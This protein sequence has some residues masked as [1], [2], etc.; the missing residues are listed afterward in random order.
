MYWNLHEEVLKLIEQ[1]PE[2]VINKQREEIN[3]LK[4]EI[5]SQKEQTIEVQT[6]QTNQLTKDIKEIKELIQEKNGKEFQCSLC[7]FTS[8][9]KETVARH[10]NKKI[11][12]GEGE[13]VILEIDVDIICE[14]CKKEFATQPSLK[15]HQKTCKVKK[16][17]TKTE[18]QEVKE[19]IKELQAK[20]SQ[21]TLSQSLD[22]SK[23]I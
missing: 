15:R 20:L 6:T 12:C 13:A 9:R 2:I 5:S 3:T 22:E 21:M 7:F 17:E 4:D 23:K 1:I 19:Q 8:E 16:E 10:I 11:K 14:F 18:L